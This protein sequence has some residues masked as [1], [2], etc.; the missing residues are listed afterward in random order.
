MRFT[1]PQKKCELVG[2][3]TGKLTTLPISSYMAGEGRLYAASVI[4]P[5]VLRAENPLN[6]FRKSAPTRQ[7]RRQSA[8]PRET[9]DVA[10]RVGLTTLFI[11]SPPCS[12]NDERRDANARSLQNNTTERRH[13]A[14]SYFHAFILLSLIHI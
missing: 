13:D 8:S 7:R 10:A 6:I 9:V 5:S 1:A 11:A 4:A 12:S 2:F 14:H 3:P